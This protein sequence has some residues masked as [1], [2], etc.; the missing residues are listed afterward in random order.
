MRSQ[1][2]WILLA[3]GGLLLPGCSSSTTQP[4]FA[5]LHQ[6]KGVVKRAGQPVKGGVVTFTGVP[7]DPAFIINSEVGPDGNYTLSTV[8]TTDT[9]GERKPG[10]PAG[11]YKVTY[12]PPLGDQTAGGQIDPIELPATVTVQAGDNDIPLVLPRR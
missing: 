10:A 8:R 2:H 6:V 12:E 3:S 4:D 7:A 5:D 1:L 9:A 11:K